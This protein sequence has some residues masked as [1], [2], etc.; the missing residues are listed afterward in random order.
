LAFVKGVTAERY[1]GTRQPEPLEDVSAVALEQVD[2]MEEEE[3]SV[4]LSEVLTVYGDGRINLNTAL[5]D[6]L[7]AIPFLSAAAIDAVLSRHQ[8]RVRKFTS[9]ADIEA[10][11]TFSELDKIVLMQVARF[12]SNVFQLQVRVKPEGMPAAYEYGAFLERDGAAVRVLSWQR[13]LARKRSSGL[14][15]IDGPGP[16]VQFMD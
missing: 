2:A 14:R 8:P 3:G 1:F 6:V 5:P 10:N 16:R 13:K 9:M 4:G 12:N 11:A 15:Q 7:K